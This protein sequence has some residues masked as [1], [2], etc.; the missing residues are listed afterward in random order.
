[1]ITKEEITKL[2]EESYYEGIKNAV[3]T[4]IEMLEGLLDDAKMQLNI[5]APAEEKC[6]D[7]KPDAR[8]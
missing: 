2:C 8:H 6:T 1:M 4:T 5:K 3:L 7:G